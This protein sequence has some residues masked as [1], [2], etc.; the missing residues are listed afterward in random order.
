V[1]DTRTELLETFLKL[2]YISSAVEN[3]VSSDA[4]LE[5]KLG[6]LLR[7]DFYSAVL[8]AQDLLRRGMVTYDDGLPFFR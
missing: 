3:L 5:E 7:D 2:G 8:T 4:G 1:E 6:L